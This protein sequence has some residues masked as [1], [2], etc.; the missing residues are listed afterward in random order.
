MLL[1][2]RLVYAIFALFAAAAA[3]MAQPDVIDGSLANEVGAGW[4]MALR[5]RGLP[6]S[7]LQTFTSALGGMA[8][9]AVRSP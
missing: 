9:A 4:H 1:P 7:N 6:G 8:A 5:P 2:R 3:A